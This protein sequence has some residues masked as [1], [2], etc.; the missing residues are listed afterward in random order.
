MLHSS[1]AIEYYGMTIICYHLASV[2]LE[3]SKAFETICHYILL[4]KL[5]KSSMRSNYLTLSQSHLSNRTQYVEI[6][7]AESLSSLIT[8]GVPQGFILVTLLF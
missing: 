1:N 7:G 3:F 4:K 5:Q 2:F 6:N 8:C